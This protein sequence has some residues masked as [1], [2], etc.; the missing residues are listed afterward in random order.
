M[1]VLRLSLLLLGLVGVSTGLL[2]SIVY[3]NTESDRKIAQLSTELDEA[4]TKQKV[5]ENACAEE[6]ENS[7]QK[8][9]ADSERLGRELEALHA[10][11]SLA[12]QAP[13]WV[14]K[15]LLNFPDA[16]L[17]SPEAARAEKMCNRGRGS[18]TSCTSRAY[19]IL[20]TTEPRADLGA[21]RNATKWLEWACPTSRPEAPKV[22]RDPDACLLL[23]RAF[24][25]GTPGKEPDKRMAAKYYKTACL[26]GSARA[27]MWAGGI[28]YDF[29]KENLLD[30]QKYNNALFLFAA[31]CEGGDG[32]GCY[33][34]A[35]AM[36]YDKT[37]T[38][39]DIW[40]TVKRACSARYAPA[41]T[42][43]GRYPGTFRARDVQVEGIF[44][45]DD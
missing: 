34:L 35:A 16:P 14:R 41:C 9:E 44:E 21:W 4:N 33:L 17:P 45:R 40:G 38:S 6:L 18:L 42:D 12:A 32:E 2:V 11:V 19:Q 29:F 43:L 39:K 30:T 1:R 36:S 25:R 5:T 23:G 22:Q 27:C 26:L 37:M 28:E 7:K 31:A 8:Y 20:G 3:I 10:S 15:G 13:E 24:R